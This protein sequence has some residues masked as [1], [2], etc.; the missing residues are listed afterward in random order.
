MYLYSRMRNGSRYW[1]IRKKERINGKPIVVL[2]KYIGTDEQLIER[3]LGGELKLL[4]SLEIQSYSFG[5]IGAIMT[6]DKELGFT[7]TVTE[8]TGSWSTALA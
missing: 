7:S 3:L 5:T 1:Y 6:A 2:N 4:E 8:V